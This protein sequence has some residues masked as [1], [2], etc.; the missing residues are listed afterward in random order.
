MGGDDEVDNLSLFPVSSR[1]DTARAVHPINQEEPHPNRVFGPIGTDRTIDV[2]DPYRIPYSSRSSIRISSR[3]ET[4]R[5]DI[6]REVCDDLQEEEIENA[7][8]LY[9][10]NGDQ[11][12]LDDPEDIADEE[13]AF[14]ITESLYKVICW[15]LFLLSNLY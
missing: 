7:R 8:Q 2:S 9:R 14:Q 15:S 13:T 11:D 6:V 3:P 5:T 1:A 4:A 10:A 12:S